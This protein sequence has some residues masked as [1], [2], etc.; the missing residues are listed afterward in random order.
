MVSTYLRGCDLSAQGDADSRGAHVV[1][2]RHSKAYIA[3]LIADSHAQRIYQR[4]GLPVAERARLEQL[5][6]AD[7]LRLLAEDELTTGSAP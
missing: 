2:D 3:G 5:A 4:A 6:I 7:G 1:P